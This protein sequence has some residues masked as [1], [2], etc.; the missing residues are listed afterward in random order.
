MSRS[1]PTHFIPRRA[2]T[3]LIPHLR[4]R[5][6]VNSQ[7]SGLNPLNAA[8]AVFNLN[9]PD[10]GIDNLLPRGNRSAEKVAR[11]SL[12]PRWTGDVDRRVSRASRTLITFSSHVRTMNRA[13]LGSWTYGYT[14][15]SSLR[16]SR[17]I[18]SGVCTTGTSALVGEP[19]SCD[20][21][22]RL[23][24]SASPGVLTSHPVA[25]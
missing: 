19:L 14:G 20:H 17:R 23:S 7:L 16:N 11:R 6:C 5:S 10:R 4:C 8:V 2:E 18:R 13:V 1:V 21:Y 3:S 24:R 25:L 9:S 22:F 12:K 15:N